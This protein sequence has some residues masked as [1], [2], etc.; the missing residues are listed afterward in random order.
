MK[1]RS[2]IF[3]IKY[4]GHHQLG[5]VRFDVLVKTGISSKVSDKRNTRVN[6]IYANRNYE[7]IKQTSAI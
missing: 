2:T 3:Y 4:K 1:E 7:S 5:G 6:T